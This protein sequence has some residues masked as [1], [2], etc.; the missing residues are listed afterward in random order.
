M[1]GLAFV[2]MCKF[3][4]H[5]G[6][7]S[8]LVLYMIEKGGLDN[9]SALTLNAV[10][11]A[12]IE[13]G[14]LCG[15]FLADRFLG[16]TKACFYGALLLGCG[17]LLL[18]GE[19]F[20]IPSLALMIVGGSLFSG[21]ITALYG[22]Q[23]GNFSFFYRMQNL[24]AL[25]STGFIPFIAKAYSFKAGFFI[26]SLGMWLGLS[27]LFCLRKTLPKKK[28]EKKGFLFL[29]LLLAIAISALSFASLS[30]L[31]LPW[32]A[33]LCFLFLGIYVLKDV[34]LI[35]YLIALIAFF[36]IEEQ[37]CS[38]LLL[39]AEK[40]G[41]GIPGALI[42]SLNPALILLLGAIVAKRRLWLST[43]F[44]LAAFSFV[45]LNLNTSFSMILVVVSL[46]SIAE[47]MVGPVVMDIASTKAKKSKE[48]IVM[49]MIPLGYCLASFL[50]GFLSKLIIAESFNAIAL[51]TLLA[52]VLIQLFIWRMSR[53]KSRVY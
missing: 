12:L 52:G 48:G 43:S 15:G 4:S 46:L 50:G 32:L 40:K 36:A 37:I 28:I 10:F 30:L 24:G 18:L 27:I 21:N 51:M 22:I 17:Y 33:I 38:S 19:K 14:A 29:P 45:L 6:M 49:A 39:I 3:F 41:N 5:F 8:L 26:A 13:L 25:V 20:F 1:N 35:I 42:M 2:Q 23:G 11:C 7:R 44:F 47:L 53:E 16:L 31:I 34:K 9:P